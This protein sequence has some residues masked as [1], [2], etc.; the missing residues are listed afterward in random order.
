MAEMSQSGHIVKM[1]TLTNAADRRNR[2]RERSGRGLFYLQES[3]AL[4]EGTPAKEPTASVKVPIT[5]D[6]CGQNDCGDGL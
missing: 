6:G 4:A 1:E 2:E 5:E 3:E